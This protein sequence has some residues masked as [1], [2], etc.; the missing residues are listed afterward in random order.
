MVIEKTQTCHGILLHNT[1]A[2]DVF[3]VRCEVDG[4][5][6]QLDWT[7]IA[8]AEAHGRRGTFE[9]AV[10]FTPEQEAS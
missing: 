1:A 3:A 4:V 8:P 6:R 2:L 5:W 10:R 9:I 7:D